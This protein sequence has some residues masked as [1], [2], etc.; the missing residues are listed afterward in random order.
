MKNSDKQITIGTIM[1]Y[2]SIV[3]SCVGAIFVTPFIVTSLGDSSYGVYRIIVSLI[4]YMSILNFGFGNSAI[5]YLSEFRLKKQKDR[6]KEFLIIIKFLNYLAVLVSVIVGIIIYNFIGMVF[7]K[8]LTVEEIGLAKEL[9][10][11]LIIG[12]I[13]S[14]FNDIYAAVI[15]A[16]ERFAFV[17]SLDVIRNIL[18]IVLVFAILTFNNSAVYLTLIDLALN[19]FILLSNM[20]YCR[21][22]LK[23]R[24]NGMIT[25]L[26]NLDK[27]F[28]K[29]VL[30]YAFIVLLNLIINQLIWNTD[31]LIIGMRLDSTSASIYG[32]GT[33]ISS[34]FYNMSLVIGNMLMPKTVQMVKGG[35]T[36]SQLT[37]YMIEIA[38][39]QAFIIL[40][41]VSA[42]FA[43]GKQFITLWMGS[44]YLDA[45]TSSLYVMIGTI[46]A[47]LLVT[48]HAILK[49]M[50]RQNFFMMTYF[51][52]FLMNVFAT[53]WIVGV[54]GIVGA[55]FVTMVTFAGGSIFILIPYYHKV[56]G[57]DMKK[58]IIN[59]CSGIIPVTLII[60]LVLNEIFSKCAINSWFKFFVFAIVYTVI[61]Y[62]FIYIFA[63]KKEEKEKIHKKLSHILK[64][65]DH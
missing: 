35:A 34:M 22:K 64:K 52:I 63:T 26:D 27:A 10:Q 7:S 23:I 8:S 37:D 17:K 20:Y 54:Q 43:L 21:C 14:I 4:S 3:I 65:G 53:Y 11:I 57:L 16:Y 55:A 6:E 1:S 5:R 30:V 39:I 61:Y 25:K 15:N 2:L 41:I 44:Q 47:S 36:K 24:I 50:N 59:L 62:G 13:V 42:Y 33:T 49:A 48:G 12:V 29:E 19:I 51:I 18:K 32:V 38:R 58:L 31:S 56:I 28:Y 45:W 40:F 60:A 9:F 46:F